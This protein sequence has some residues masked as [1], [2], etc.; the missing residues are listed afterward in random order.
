VKPLR[1]F[2]KARKF[3]RKFVKLFLPKWIFNQY[4]I[5]TGSFQKQFFIKFLEVKPVPTASCPECSE[6]VY[7]DADSEQGDV[8]TCDECGSDLEVVGLD[9][10]ELDLYVDKGEKDDYDEVDFDSLDYE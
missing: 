6:K 9:P 8:V 5:S 10:V 4:H 7:V 2:L 1:G 3:Y